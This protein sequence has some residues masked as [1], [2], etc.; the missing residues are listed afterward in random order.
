[1]EKTIYILEVG[2]QNFSDE[3]HVM[4]FSRYLF[5]QTQKHSKNDSTKYNSFIVDGKINYVE[6]GKN[7]LKDFISKKQKDFSNKKIKNDLQYIYYIFKIDNIVISNFISKIDGELNIISDE[8]SLK[9]IIKKYYKGNENLLNKE[10]EVL[11]NDKY[12]ILDLPEIDNESRILFDEY[13]HSFVDE[14]IKKNK[15]IISM[16]HTD[17]ESPYH[18]HRIY[19]D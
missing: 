17:Q 16:S 4:N 12:E 10:L 3:S 6:N 2:N 5:S 11:D 18:I 14:K 8:E 9:M 1:M 7:D 13:I 15:L 19:L